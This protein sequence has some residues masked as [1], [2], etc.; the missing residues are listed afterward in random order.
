MFLGVSFCLLTSCN[1]FETSIKKAEQ[2]AEKGDHTAQFIVAQHYRKEKKCSVANTWFEKSI[3][4]GNADAMTEFAISYLDGNCVQIDQK[5]AFKY[6]K[7]AADL[8]DANAQNN[9]GVSYVTGAG[10]EKNL[11]VAFNLFEESA[12]K[13]WSEAQYNL[14]IC[15]AKG[16][17]V[18]EDLIKAKEWF[19]K[20]KIRGVNK[21][22]SKSVERESDN[23][24]RHLDSFND[25]SWVGNWY[26]KGV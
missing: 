9:L 11:K 1:D 24:L 10:I 3:A 2:E 15:Y 23:F 25:D 6:F 13:G 14:G 19:E 16:I 17:F 26:K 21:K 4:G 18:K 5:K 22:L 7:L 12:K 8:K 20:A